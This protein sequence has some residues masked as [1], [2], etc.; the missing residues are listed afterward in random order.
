VFLEPA[1]TNKDTFIRCNIILAICDDAFIPY[2]RRLSS[3]FCVSHLLWMSCACCIPNTMGMHIGDQF[4]SAIRLQT[5]CTPYEYNTTLSTVCAVASVAIQGSLLGE[6]GSRGCSAGNSATR[7]HHDRRHQ[8]RQFRTNHS[9][10]A[11]GR[12]ITGQY[13]L[14]S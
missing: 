8:K 5:T 4:R 14:V 9:Q 7:E 13:K 2:K 11:K 3:Q 12:A 10:P 1:P 6:I